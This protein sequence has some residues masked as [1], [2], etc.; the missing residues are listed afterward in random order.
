MI[1]ARA[2]KLFA[3]AITLSLVIVI[4]FEL[5]ERKRGS[6]E[7]PFDPVDQA[8]QLSSEK[9][10]AESRLLANF[11]IQH[12]HLGD[13]R[14][15]GK[16][17]ERETQT[18]ESLSGKLRRFAHGAASG[19][20]TDGAS[21]LGSMSLDFFVIGDIRDILVQGYREITND[22][23]DRLILGLSAIGLAT[24]LTPEFDWAPSMLKSFKRSGALNPK[25]GKN[26]L[27]ISDD[28][29]K[30][31][32]FGK[33]TKVTQDFAS[34]ARKMGP[35]PLSGAVRSVDS[36]TDMS[37]LS[38]AAAKDFRG[39]YVIA[40]GFGNVGVKK[41]AK[42]GSNIATLVSKLRRSSRAVKVFRKTVSV[43]PT[44]ILVLVVSLMLGLLVRSPLVRLISRGRL[45]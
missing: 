11:V 26:L 20:P 1:F 5:I 42:D 31:R 12:P 17:V 35:G 36:A 32:N 22:D 41:I 25:F 3:K 4:S 39:T 44:V 2:T 29:V 16:I 38:R 37:R 30:S 10:H 21:L 40:T 34:A 27:K 19:E 6:V 7:L 18:L 45:N 43:V 9:R 15:A 24:T 14:E 33:L 8:Q 13:Q 23:G 28:A